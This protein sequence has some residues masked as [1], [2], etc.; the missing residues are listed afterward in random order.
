MLFVR[1]YKGISHNPLEN[2]EPKDIAAAIEVSAGFIN[3]VI[4]KYTRG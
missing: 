1:C 2:V 4:Q 3:S